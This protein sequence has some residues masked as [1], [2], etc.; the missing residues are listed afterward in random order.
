MKIL[1]SNKK[2]KLIS[3]SESSLAQTKKF[4]DKCN[5]AMK[6]IVDPLTTGSVRRFYYWIPFC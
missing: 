4:I 2:C 3:R 1:K 5:F 6:L